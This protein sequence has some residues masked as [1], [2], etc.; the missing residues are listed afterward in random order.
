MPNVSAQHFAVGDKGKYSRRNIEFNAEGTLVRGWLYLPKVER[1]KSPAIIMAHGFG[2]LKEMHLDQFAEVFASSGF[3]VVVFDYRS[4]GDSEGSPRNEV[5]PYKQIEDYRHAITFATT[6]DEIDEQRIGVW[7]TSYSGGHV[8]VV[9]ATDHRVK[10]VVSQVPTVSG[11][12]SSLRR[13]PPERIPALHEAFSED[14]INRMNG[15]EPSIRTLVSYNSE[16]RPVYGLDEAV[17]WYSEAGERS[18]NWTN[19]VTLRSVEFSRSYNPGAYISYIAPV[20]LLMIVGKTDYVTP[21]DL[22]LQAYSSALEPKK[23]ELLE[24]GHFDPY[25]KYFSTSSTEATQ[26]FMKHL[27]VDTEKLS[28]KK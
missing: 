13:V 26:W 25:V 10:C 3:A 17:K 28:H 5:D 9:A 19:Q 27:H 4:F 11:K 20:P 16:D 1:K 2:S 21:T 24:G 14:R 7:G 15:E 6:I 22:A 8:L 18:P 23:L 12:Q